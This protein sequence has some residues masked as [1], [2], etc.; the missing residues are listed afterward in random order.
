MALRLTAQGQDPRAEPQ[1]RAVLEGI[2]E[3]F[4]LIDED[5]LIL[6]WNLGAEATFGWSRTEALGARMAELLIPA[7]QR[8]A[9]R[10]GLARVLAG[11]ESRLIG[12][13]VEVV[14]QHRDGHELALELTLSRADDAGRSRFAALLHDVSERK[15]A[16]RSL[17]RLAAIVE[18][19]QDAII[20]GG[21][22][23][24]VET[25]SPGAE[26]LFGYTAAEAIGRSALRLLPA[27]DRVD[28]L[29]VEDDLRQGR[30]VAREIWGRCKD[31]CLVELALNLSPLTDASGAVIGVAAVA[32]DVTERNRTVA[33]L[34]QAHSRFAG[35]FDAATIGMALV[36][37]DGRFLEVNAAL[38]RLLGRE[39]EQL[40]SCTFQ[41][42]THPDDLESDVEQ[43]EALL[44]GEIETYVLAKRYLLPGGGIVWGLL[45]VTAVRDAGGELQHVVSQIE[46]I[47]ARRTAND[48]L[49]RYA[50][51]LTGLTDRDAQTGLANRRAFLASLA[52]E[53][54]LQAAGGGAC[55]VLLVDVDP[56]PEL[57][58][59]AAE[60]LQEASRSAD[61]VAHLGG[62]ELAVLLT[63]ADALSAEE[64][65]LRVRTALGERLRR[66]AHVSSLPN[67]APTELLERA[68]R[69][70]EPGLDPGQGAPAGVE[71][72]LDFAREQLGMGISFLTRL[73]GDS[74]VFEGLSGDHEGLG[75]SQGDVMPLAGTHCRRMLDGSIDSTV[76]DLLA[77]PETRDLDVT[78]LTGLRAYAGVPVRLRSGEL[79]G[80]LCAVDR[81]VQPDLG[82]RDVELLRFLSG[83]VAELIDQQ[84]VALKQRHAE[85]STTGVRA[86]LGALEARDYY[87]GEHSKEVVAL[88]GAV[89]RRLGHT[90]D[91][92]RDI[93]QVA[94]L[95]DIGKLGFPTR[96]CR[97]RARSTIRSGSSCASTPS[98]AS[99]SSPASPTWPTSP[100]RC[101]PST[102]AGT[103]AGTPTA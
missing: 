10:A 13:R 61:M 91:V 46:D 69:L 44:A 2:V 96:S 102:N 86:L 74:Y 79:Y 95:H 19:S 101:A 9:H 97:S 103:A 5:G 66:S 8:L 41:E 78:R 52:E 30:A 29:A 90:A 6:D 25:W 77:H 11:G 50:A 87:T 31:G 76:G 18:A 73:D 98:S 12:R 84:A 48:E 68:R 16:Q 59:E 49:A 63:A 72:L 75:V 64:V 51:Q 32:R 39:A 89:A 40:R 42:L 24:T 57:L 53:L 26:R 33:R 27:G 58:V 45:T 55:G 71:R 70:G 4:V 54:H 14:G 36:A 88:A 47:T 1:I 92:V 81:Q 99:T 56:D 23:W 93:E 38:C 17:R 20:S 67:E 85:S 60:R 15:E 80:T 65:E 94:L 82:P 21:L 62:G 7:E 34:A 28:V 43:L 22:D 35:A 83:L 100:P 3:A 37:P